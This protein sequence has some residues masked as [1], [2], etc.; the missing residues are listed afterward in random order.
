MAQPRQAHRRAPWVDELEAIARPLRGDQWRLMLF[1]RPAGPW[2][3]DRKQAELDAVLSG[4]G[5]IEESTGTF[6]ATVPAWLQSR[7]RPQP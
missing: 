1:D 4:N 2:R 6:Y 3:D 5:S 7:K